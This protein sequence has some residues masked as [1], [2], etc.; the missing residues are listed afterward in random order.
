MADCITYSLK[1]QTTSS[2]ISIKTN[3]DINIDKY[4]INLTNLRI[5]T[6]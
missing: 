4:F 2:F 5:T 6:L 1:N 3:I